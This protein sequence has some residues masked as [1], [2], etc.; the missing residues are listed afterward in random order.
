MATES[1]DE[2]AVSGP[3]EAEVWRP[4]SPEELL[5]RQ[6]TPE[7]TEPS[8]PAVNIER[9]QEL[10][11]MVR[12]MPAALEP[13]LELAAIYHRLERFYDAQRVLEKARTHHAENTELLWQLEETQL[14]RALQRLGEVRR[15]VQSTRAPQARDELERCQVEWAV[16]R[17]EVCRARLARDA[18]RPN[19][20]VKLGEAERDLGHLDAALEAC[21]RVLDHPEH[22]AAAAL[23]T[24]QCHALRGNDLEALAAYRAAGMRRS[25]TAAPA[26]RLAAMRGAAALAARRGL[27]ASGLRYAAAWHELAPED[28]DALATLRHLESLSSDA[29]EIHGEE[30]TEN[31]T[32]DR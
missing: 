29:A 26:V 22:G 28:P 13:Y 10:E 24:A 6:A 19:L 3:L 32:S 20:W 1:S 16:R 18:D 8:V 23:V 21:A 5:R 25:R 27:V 9:R 14:A 31:A 17:A 30:E 2:S 15:L 11:R 7:G 12:N 4:A